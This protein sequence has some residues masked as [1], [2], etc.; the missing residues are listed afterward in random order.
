MEDAIEHT[1]KVLV[2]GAPNVMEE[3]VEELTGRSKGRW[4]LL[5]VA[6]VVG[7]A[8]AAVTIRLGMRRAAETADGP[9][10]DTT[11]TAPGSHASEA[12]DVNSSKTSAWS[13]EPRADCPL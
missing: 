8:V 4:A 2:F 3:A 9:D 5:L 10:T 6:F 7:L 1:G 11:A 12:R 13:F